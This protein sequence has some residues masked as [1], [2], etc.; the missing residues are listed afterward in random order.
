[1]EFLLLEPHLVSSAGHYN[2]YVR[3]FAGEAKR[4]GFSLS[5]ASSREI[6]PRFKTMLEELGVRVLPMFDPTPYRMVHDATRRDMVSRQIADAAL[7]S[8]RAC[9]GAHP[10]WLSGT[11]A[12]LGGACLFAEEIQ[13]PFLF[14]MLDFAE[15][16]PVGTLTAPAPLRE[17]VGQ[18]VGS[19]LRLY[20]QSAQIANHL[21][22]EIDAPVGVF[23]AILDLKPLKHRP[24]RA[25]PVVG[26]TN[27][28]RTSKEVGPALSALMA[29][30]DSITLVLHTG[31]GTTIEAVQALKLRI[32]GLARH[33]RLKRE[34]VR[35]IPGVLPSHEYSEMWQSIDCTVMPYNPLR[36][37]RQG[38]GMLFESLADAIIP[39]APLG[40]SMA[41][42]MLE[43]GM[44]LTYDPEEHGS[45]HGTISTMLQNLET[46]TERLRAFAPIYREANSPAKVMDTVLLVGRQ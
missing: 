7:A 10:V 43:L 39:I 5:V 4:R 23:P 14:Q 27:M 45:L 41:T 32:D 29:H 24:R 8:L 17:A 26:I 18:A 42:T 15:D 38:S 31:Q 28:L 44:G 25:R 1:M 35:I 6:L 2:R 36:Y 33:Y 34:D 11:G 13:R 21:R 3:V 9:P 22:N 46:M 37:L 40:T 12:L 30:G 16:W 20:A 19:G